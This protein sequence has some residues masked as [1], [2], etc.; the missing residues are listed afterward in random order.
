MSKKN[1][2]TKRQK[3]Q[4]KQNK[5]AVSPML[6]GVVGLVAILLVG[7]LIWLGSIENQPL[8]P[9]DVSEFPALGPEDAQ[10]TIIEYSD[11]G[12]PH[13]RDFVLNTS[14]RLIE[15]YVETDQVRYIVHPFSL[16]QETALA[17]EA[18]WCAADQGVFFEYQHAL[19]E[20]F[21]ALDQSSLVAVANQV[22]MNQDAF[23]D[24]LSSRTHRNDVASAVQAAA[25]QGV[26]ATPTFFINGQRIEGNQPFDVFERVIQQELRIGS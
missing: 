25:R 4:Q 2:K 1:Q 19:F 6:I 7:G 12:C 20:N 9:V 14:E 3:L 16:R 23:G 11:Y 21:G 18:A 15:T 24:C 10:V 17:A 8:E 26:Q 22:E 5:P 13:C